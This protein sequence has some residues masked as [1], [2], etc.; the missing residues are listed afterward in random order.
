MPYTLTM[1]L[2]WFAAAFVL[3]LA[4]GALVRTVT[5][6]HR[7]TRPSP[8]TGTTPSAADP[9]DELL[10][11]IAELEQAEAE[12]DA[13]RVELDAM[14]RGGAGLR[15]GGRAATSG[16]LA[17]PAPGQPDVGGATAV[18]GRPITA[19]DLTVVEGI[20]PHVAMLCHWI[21]IHTWWDLSV[22]EVSLL[23]T[24]LADAGS[25]FAHVDPATWPSQG[26]LLAEGRWQEFADLTAAMRS[27]RER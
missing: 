21:G 26:R 20:E 11:R 1:G 12:R 15:S 7:P 6:R 9:V 23:R 17:P 5:Q 19:D 13:L 16:G 14:R 8:A 10:A 27:G 3:G 25:R 22:T 18:L 2:L 24:M 4:T